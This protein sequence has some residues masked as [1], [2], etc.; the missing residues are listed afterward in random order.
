[1]QRIEINTSP[2][3][4]AIDNTDWLKTVAII[5]VT[6]DHFGYFFIEDNQWWSL[7]GRLAA[8]VFF[9]L[10]GYAETR[11]VPFSWIWTG[12]IL[13]VLDSWNTNWAWVAP[14][15]L[16]SLALIRLARTNVQFLLRRHGWPSYLLLTAVLIA[17]VPITT[18]FVEYGS[19]GW[20]WALFGLGQRMYIDSRAVTAQS[21]PSPATK[22]NPGLMRLL[23]GLVASVVCV[24]QEQLEYSF[25]E[26]QLAVLI[27][28]ISGLSI[29]LC[30][31]R[32]GP[33]RIQLPQL[34][35]GGLH[36]IGRHT[37]EIYAIQLAGF[38]IIIN[39]LPDLAL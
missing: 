30:Q 34:F 26:T 5:L 14:N 36:F 38:E 13:T 33:S 6:I 15:I 12:V 9:F 23:A 16:L 8:P 4:H 17:A 27:L 7:T 2:G 31:F 39:M 22:P 25:S 21:T 37:L 19:E 24:W 11:K 1:M 10:L 35:A 18:E 20:L 29:S 3:F 32:R 28:G